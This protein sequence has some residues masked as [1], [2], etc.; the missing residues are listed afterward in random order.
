[1]EIEPSPTDCER[2][3]HVEFLLLRW[4]CIF[5]KLKGC[6]LASLVNVLGE[7]ANAYSIYFFIRVFQNDY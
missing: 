7:I 3:F 1:M 4:L 5:I 6:A 2:F